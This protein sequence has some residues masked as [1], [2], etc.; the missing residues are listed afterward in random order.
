MTQDDLFQTATSSQQDIHASRSAL[1]ASDEARK[2][3]VTSGQKYLPL[4]KQSGR[5]GAFS[6]MF[7][8]TSTWASTKCYLTWKVKATPS[9]RLLFQLA[10]SMPR[11]DAIEFGSLLHTPTAKANQMS[12]DMV[13]KGSGWWPTPVADDTGLRKKKY[14]QGGTPLSLAAQEPQMWAT[15]RTTDATGGPRK[16][17]ERGRRISQNNLNLVFGANSADQIRMWPTPHANCH[18][19]PGNQGRAGGDNIQ[20]A[21]KMW[22]TPTANED[23]AGTPNGNMQRQLGNH[24]DIRGTTPEE[25]KMGSLN[26]AWVEWLMGYPSGWTNLETSQE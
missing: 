3:T 8:D 23:A 21:V 18:T 11:T 16:L 24:P 6:R 12:P 1:P 4:C 10:P 26:P 20:T 7:L 5:V 9:N 14:S 25:W 17:D 22:P 19:G 15:P 2:M 13:K